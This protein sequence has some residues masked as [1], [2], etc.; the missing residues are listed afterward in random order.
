MDN[1]ILNPFRKGFFRS[2]VFIYLIEFTLILIIFLLLYLFNISSDK[3]QIFDKYIEYIIEFVLFTILIKKYDLKIKYLIGDYKKIKIKETFDKISISIYLFSFLLFTYLTFFYISK[4]T[5]IDSFK[6]NF[7]HSDD[8]DLWLKSGF[9][10]FAIFSNITNI[11]VVCIFAPIFEEVFFR[12]FIFH[13][14]AIKFD[15]EKS[16]IFTS[17]LF[18]LV[19]GSSFLQIS[20]VGYLL[21]IVYL[22]YKNLTYN[23]LVHSIYNFLIIIFKFILENYKPFYFNSIISFLEFF[24]YISIMIFSFYKIITFI[25]NNIPKNVNNESLPYFSNYRKMNNYDYISILYTNEKPKRIIRKILIYLSSFI[26][27][28]IFS[29]S[30]LIYF[31]YSDFIKGLP[32]EEIQVNNYI[33]N[34]QKNP[35]ISNYNSIPFIVWQSKGQD[36]DNWGVYGKKIKFDKE[37]NLSEDIIISQTSKGIQEN[38]VVENIGENFIVSWNGNGNNDESGIYARFFDKNINPL[39]DEFLVNNEISGEQSNPKIIKKDNNNFYITWRN[40]KENS[41]SIKEYSS[42]NKRNISNEKK[43]ILP[44]TF[45][46]K[47]S[48]FVYLKNQIV[49]SIKN[50]DKIYLYNVYL[51]SKKLKND[52]LISNTGYNPTIN[53]IDYKKFLISWEDYDK[54]SKKYCIKTKI[55][56]NNF[57]EVNKDCFIQQE[58]DLERFRKQNSFL[59]NNQIYSFWESEDIPYEQNLFIKVFSIISSLFKKD[60]G[61]KFF[62]PKSCSELQI[63]DYGYK[64]QINFKVAYSNEE[65]EDQSC[66]LV[67][68]ESEEQDGDK[69][70]IFYKKIYIDNLD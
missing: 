11:L 55:Y 57:M 18:G 58:N 70:G 56:N 61:I 65:A 69:S 9:D 15:V 51:N 42:K 33:K 17:F 49:L 10:L 29:I 64:N 60:Y 39:T 26:L 34:D 44:N 6:F 54:N 25:K 30:S 35:S 4:I 41:I 22:K 40:I 36:G 37:N 66:F 32:V 28:S 43:I 13:R 1:H 52:K 46:L 53:T 7:G 16:V 47:T 31:F 38:P 20:I 12:G 67:V 3:I 5:N 68:W 59:V 21:C 23:I 24:T 27:I 45:N 48:S 14:L 19:H 2:T 50:E 62:N 8:S 63:N